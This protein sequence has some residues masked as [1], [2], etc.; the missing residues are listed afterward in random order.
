[1][2]CPL[3]INNNNFKA[4]I[5]TK[6]S[7]EFISE[8][9]VRGF[10]HQA[11]DLNKLD[12]I[13]SKNKPQTGYI[14]FDC[15]A[16]S[17]HVGS[18]MQIMLLRWFQKTGHRPIVLLGGG[19][20]LIGDPSGKDESR[21]LLNEKTISINSKNIK[22]VFEKFINFKENSQSALMINNAEWLT[23]LSYI[24]FLRD[25]GKH[26]SVNR[27]LNFD[28]VK[29]RLER[30]Q[31][32]SFLEFNYMILQAYD[33]L[34]LNRQYGC[35]LQMGGSDQWGNIVNGV[36]LNR[37]VSASSS[38][39]EEL[40]GLTS[41][42]ITN[43]NGGKM[44]KTEKGAIWLDPELLSPWEYWQFWRNT[45]DQDVSKFLKLFT[46]IDIGEINKLEKLAGEEINEAK[47][48]LATEATALLH[49]RQSAEKSENT[50]KHLFEK[51]GDENF[52]PKVYIDY[53]ILNKKISI[54]D[55]FL[56]NNLLSSKSEAR[57]L[58]RGGG[59]KINDKVI[60]NES[61]L[62]DKSFFTSSNDI[63]LSAGKKRHIRIIF[64]KNN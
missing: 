54:L 19:T 9:K 34:E 33:F 29:L 37:R 16:K 10:I 42:L 47:K 23:K 5:M 32:L 18:L 21:K 44:G 35:I 2:L 38:K 46:E 20:T 53:E 25:F 57:R 15:T 41:P 61:L 64:K 1:M 59:A 4:L 7:S 36:E 24:E 55:L 28:S 63:K 43:S 30:E 13:L 17:L 58:I 56:M 12:S 11:T 50:G 51:I 62:V 6:V 14:G 52:L 31:T 48:V 39:S 3:K 45:T 27:M 60:K 49:G 40:Y 22:K 8:I 26:F